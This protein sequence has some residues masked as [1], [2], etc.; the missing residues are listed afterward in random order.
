MLTFL[1][2]W[3]AHITMLQ[4]IAA[5]ALYN[6]FSYA[7]QNLTYALQKTSMS[8]LEALSGLLPLVFFYTEA[9]IVFT[10]EW[11]QRYPAL[12]VMLLMPSYCLMT[13]RHIICSVTRMIF[14]WRQLNPLWFLL[15]IVNKAL[16]PIIRKHIKSNSNLAA[17]KSLQVEGA[18][19]NDILPES[20]V[21]GI[22]FSVTFFLFMKFTI[23]TINQITS[24]LGINCLTIK[25]KE[26]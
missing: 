7:Y 2:D 5:V 4:I 22:V 8:K 21:A 1:P 14:D 23:D 26:V 10:T 15:F 19:K 24:F 3:A 16:I 20:W 25:K 11:G 9:I 6:A 12:A 17:L 18:A 13:C